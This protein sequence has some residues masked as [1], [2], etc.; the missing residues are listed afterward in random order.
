MTKKTTEIIECDEIDIKLFSEAEQNAFY[1]ALLTRIIDF[2]YDKNK[3]DAP[4]ER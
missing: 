1:N 2:F 3:E 4:S